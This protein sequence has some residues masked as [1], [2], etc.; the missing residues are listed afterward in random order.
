MFVTFI[1]I[2]LVFICVVL[3]WRT[4][5]THTGLPLKFGCDI[6]LVMCHSSAKSYISHGKDIKNVHLVH[7]F[8]YI[9]HPVQVVHHAV[10]NAYSSHAI[11]ASSS[12]SFAHGTPRHNTHNA[13][14]IN[15]P[16]VKENASSGSSISYRTFDVSYVL[17]CKFGKVVASH[18]GPKCKKGKTCVWVPKVYVTNLRVSNSVWVPKP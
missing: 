1:S 17:Y 8:G 12:T 13:R 3:I 18:V 4:Y 16:K 6:W 14:L 11:I 5:E 10:R 2:P 9:V 7:D 15:E